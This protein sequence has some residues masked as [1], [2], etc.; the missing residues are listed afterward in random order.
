MRIRFLK[1]VNGVTPVLMGASGGGSFGASSA[2]S[3]VMRFLFSPLVLAILLF[4]FLLVALLT[5][6]AS[7]AFAS[8]DPDSVAVLAANTSGLAAKLKEVQ[9]KLTERREKLKSIFEAGGSDRDFAKKEVLDITGAKDSA[10]VVA[11]INEIS[12]E[13]EDLGKKADEYGSLALI[14]E[15]NDK[16]LKRRKQ[17]HLQPPIP[18]ADPAE[19]KERRGNLGELITKSD[20]Y[21]TYLENKAAGVTIEIKEGGL[22]DLQLKTLFQ[23]SAGWAPESTRIDRIVEAVT[24]PIQVLDL[25]P[26]FP[27]G[28]AA[29]PFMEE[30]TRTHNAAERTEGAAY[31]EDA[32]A[33]TEQSE[34]VRLIGTS[35]PV[36]DEQLEDIPQAEG[37]LTQRL[38][39]SCRQRFDGQVLNGNG[40]SPNLRGINNKVGIQ[41]QAKGG[42]PTPDAFY[43]AM[44]KVLVTGRAFPNAIVMH[45][46]D[47]QEI[48]LLRTA[49]GIYIW[50]SPSEVGPERMWG[51]QVAKSDAQAEGTGLVG[52]FL[53]HCAAFERRGI[54]IQVGFV[55]ANFGEGKKTI[56]AGFRVAF[57]VFRAAAFCQVTGI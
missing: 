1:A 36:T 46:N 41:T 18:G 44:T 47:W 40:S 4:A 26:M 32:F 6:G 28:Q 49:D 53:N 48:R 56:R 52:D 51:A 8:P 3:A 39:F 27:T 10:G 24:R 50:G 15:N 30:T 2:P 43:K 57:I 19:R 34:T 7:P 33:L 23:T 9:G 21:K 55:N 12:A 14:E 35:I 29:V 11:K 42:D 37:Y 17:P 13:C 45:P 25:I 16:E 20:A 38:I 22:S 5:F 54:E 31:G